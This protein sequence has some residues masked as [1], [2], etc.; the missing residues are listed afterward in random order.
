MRTAE[1]RIPLRLYQKRP[2]KVGQSPGTLTTVGQKPKKPTGVTVLNYDHQKCEMQQ[3]G[4]LSEL[5]RL[6]AN[7]TNSWINVEGFTDTNIVAEIGQI[8]DIHPLVL[9]DTVNPRQ[10]IGEYEAL[11]EAALDPYVM[12]RNAYVQ[13]RNKLIAE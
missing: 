6:K 8:F 12:I 4:T 9:E 1:K 13:N 11:K 3:I 5:G 2:H 7:S 10:R